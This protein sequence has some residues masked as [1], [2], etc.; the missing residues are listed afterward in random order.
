MEEILDAIIAQLNIIKDLDYS[1]GGFRDEID[2]VQNIWFGNPGILPSQQYPY[3]YVEPQQSVPRDANTGRIRRAL[4]VRIILLLDP[5]EL[6][7]DSEI[8]EATASREMIRTMDSIERWFEK[9]Q[10]RT[11]DGL[12]PGVHSVVVSTTEYAQQVRG[13]LYS[14]GASILLT[15]DKSRP[16]IS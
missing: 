11:P 2:L 13:A 14:Q 6:W 10:F 4:T 12:T 8:V 7:D 3:I 15:I 1:D 5:R 16:R 9:D